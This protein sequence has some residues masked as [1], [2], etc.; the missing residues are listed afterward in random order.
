M[1]TLRKKTV[2]ALLTGLT[3]LSSFSWADTVQNL[4][5]ENS[6]MVQGPAVLRPKPPLSGPDY[7]SFLKI[8]KDTIRFGEQIP[9][10]TSHMILTKNSL[11]FY[12]DRWDNTSNSVYINQDQI[13]LARKINN[14]SPRT[15]L[16]QGTILFSNGYT[17]QTT[18]DFNTIVSSTTAGNSRIDG[19]IITV[20]SGTSGTTTISGGNLTAAKLS[21]PFINGTTITGTTVN[22]TTMNSQKFIAS[23][24]ITSPHAQITNLDVNQTIR[25]S[26]INTQELYVVPNVWADYVFKPDYELRSLEE[27]HSYIKENGRLPGIPSESEVMQKGVSV[28]EMQAKLLEKIEEMTLHMIKMQ[29]RIAQLEGELK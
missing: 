2:P 21:A 26:K 8:S 23:N 14:P 12:N 16:K 11:S 20:S 22:G 5:V 17:N 6:L 25:A 18:I 9:N 4:T 24:T 15:I 10:W 27:V 7:Y 29:E 28:G 1:W 19:P 13:T 3:L